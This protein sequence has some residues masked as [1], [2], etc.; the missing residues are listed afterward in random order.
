MLMHPNL[1]VPDLTTII[2][3]PSQTSL[4]AGLQSETG[5]VQVC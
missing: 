4:M 2:G 3:A 1:S 5:I